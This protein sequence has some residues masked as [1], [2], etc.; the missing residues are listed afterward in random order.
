LARIGAPI[1]FP[2]ETSVPEATH[3]LYKAME[4]MR[5]ELRREKRTSPQ[6]EQ[7]RIEQA[8]AVN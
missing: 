5:E 8:Q 7:A 2:A 6:L 4:K 1:H 3:T